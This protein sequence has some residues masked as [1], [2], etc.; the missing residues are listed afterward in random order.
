MQKNALSDIREGEL[1]GG[2]RLRDNLIEG[3]LRFDS[4]R[5]GIAG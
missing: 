1:Q 3:E 4:L 2:F 5:R